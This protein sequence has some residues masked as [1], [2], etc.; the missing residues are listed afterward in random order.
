MGGRFPREKVYRSCNKVGKDVQVEIPL[1]PIDQCEGEIRH[2]VNRCFEKN[3]PIKECFYNES[4]D[5]KNKTL[6]PFK[7][8]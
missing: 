3:C 8:D 4:S 7:I 6:D 1:V 5:L 2:S